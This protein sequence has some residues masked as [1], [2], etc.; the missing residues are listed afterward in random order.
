MITIPYGKSNIINEENMEYTYSLPID[1]QH[2]ASTLCALET[3][4]TVARIATN[5][6]FS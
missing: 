3:W 5:S 1:E 4:E 2:R 6:W